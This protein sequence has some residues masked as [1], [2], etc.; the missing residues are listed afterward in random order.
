MTIG[1]DDAA[2]VID[3]DHVAVATFLAAKLHSPAASRIHRCALCSGVIDTLVRADAIQDGMIA[4]A[5]E[6]RADAAFS[7]VRP[8]GV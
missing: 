2:A 5:A 3:L 7:I 4:T 8:A 1:G 6:A